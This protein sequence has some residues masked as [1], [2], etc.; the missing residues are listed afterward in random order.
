[1]KKGPIYDKTGATSAEVDC[2]ICIPEHPPCQTP[3]RDL[4]LAE[5]VYAA[6]EVKPDIS[7]LTSDSEFGRSLK[8]ARTVK[9]LKRVIDFAFGRRPGSWPVE[10]ERIPY[11]V[12]AK[13]V[14]D[15]KRVAEFMDRT[16]Q[17]GP[18]SAWD[19]PDI[20][21]GYQTGLLFHAA[22]A[23]TCSITPLFQ[24]HGY[25]AGEG[26]LIIPAGRDT[27]ILLLALV[28]SFAAPKPQLSEPILRDYLFP[29][30]L[31]RG[32]QVLAAT[33]ENAPS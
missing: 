26:Y 15:L 20:I 1:M 24:R 13:N 9:L 4:I 27:L 5:G 7:S 31:P 29:I 32:A 30:G 21:V 10:A 33:S 11:I 22:D 12:F 19:L 17:T 25:P 3:S 16:K 2:A 28:I 18:W 8:Q 23:S 14:P 6:I